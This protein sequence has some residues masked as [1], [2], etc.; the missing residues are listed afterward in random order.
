M[1]DKNTIYLDESCDFDQAVAGTVF[2]AGS[3]KHDAFFVKRLA[4]ATHSLN[5][6][7][8][9]KQLLQK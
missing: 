4:K 6:G 2:S 9:A 7:S 3:I 1:V 5:V 8:V